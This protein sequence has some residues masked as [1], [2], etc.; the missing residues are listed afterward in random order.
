MRKKSELRRVGTKIEKGAK[1]YSEYKLKKE[2]E[3]PKVTTREE[4]EAII[5]EN[6]SRK[7]QRCD[8]TENLRVCELLSSEKFPELKFDLENGI[9]LCEFHYNIFKGL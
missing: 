3:K 9:T 7:C 8:A 6:D 2:V 5:F 1:V 4:W